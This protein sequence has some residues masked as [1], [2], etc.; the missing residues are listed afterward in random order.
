MQFCRLNM[1]KALE[2][3]HVSLSGVLRYRNVVIP[4][5]LKFFNFAYNIIPPTMTHLFFVII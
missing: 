4:Y 5:F 2:I 1:N 3:A